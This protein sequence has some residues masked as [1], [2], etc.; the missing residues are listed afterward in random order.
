MKLQ[1]WQAFVGV[2]ARRVENY[3]D[4]LLASDTKVESNSKVLGNRNQ[5]TKQESLG[6]PE[7]WKIQIEK[8]VYSLFKL[9]LLANRQLYECPWIS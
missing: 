5:E 2:R 1:L 6:V 3:Y 8:V 4:N 7:K 9:L